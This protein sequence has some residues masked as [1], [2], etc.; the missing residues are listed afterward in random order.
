MKLSD[1]LIVLGL[2]VVGALQLFYLREEAATRAPV[3]TSIVPPVTAV[4]R[5]AT[6]P[7][8]PALVEPAPPAV[9]APPPSAP[10]LGERWMEATVDA[11]LA[12][13]G[14]LGLTPD[15]VAGLKDVYATCQNVRT[16]YEAE[17][18]EVLSIS[19]SQA[20]IRIPPYPVAGARLQQLFNDELKAEL[21]EDRYGAVDDYLGDTFEVAFKWFGAAVQELDVELKRDPRE[22]LMYRITARMDF[23]DT[24]NPELGMN[25]TRLFSTTSR[26]AFAA[27]TVA[28]GEWRPLARHFPR[29]PDAATAWR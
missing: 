5:P 7:E 27:E 26:Y 17:I 3:L 28:T 1:G 8:N 4:S 25:E 19:G 29:L 24:V 13:H 14:G 9:A 11:L 21:G 10:L 2:G 12:E 23:A 18:A 16:T 6:P 15:E 22:G 20:K